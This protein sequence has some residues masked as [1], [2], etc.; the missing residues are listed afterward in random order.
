VTTLSASR[1]NAA[2]P[3]PTMKDVAAAAGV[4]VKTVSRALGGESGVQQATRDRVQA[5]A[6]K[7]GFRRNDIAASL[8]RLG[9]SMATIGLLIEDVGNPFYASVTRGVEEVA[10]EHDHVVIAASSDEDP[11]LERETLSAFLS[12]RVD[13]LIVVP[14]G[15]DHSYLAPDL[16]RGTPLVFADRP[17]R[18]VEADAVVVANVRG[19]ADAVRHLIGHGHRRIGYV[20]DASG[21]YTARERYRGYTNALRSAKIKLDQSIVRQG[22]H[23]VDSAAA[24]TAELLAAEEK[25]TAI[26]AGNNRA[27]IGVLRAMRAHRGR[28]AVVGF[29]DFEL[30]DVVEPA[31]TVVAGDARALGR[32]AA[33]RLF[34]RLAGDHDPVRT[35]VLPTTLTARGSG[36]IKP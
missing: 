7:L 14:A 23:D 24:A 21:L 32:A 5:A 18:G 36:E 27:T 34:A 26:F 2:D 10:R 28:I 35:I 16:A 6:R 3:R 11:E 31:V 12:R 19:A 33:E 20:G 17:A 30:A 4:S 9:Q 13:G 15:G 25:P 8:R 1:P 29:D 22:A